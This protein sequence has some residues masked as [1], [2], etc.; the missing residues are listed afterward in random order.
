MSAGEESAAPSRSSWKTSE[1]V[2]FESARHGASQGGCAAERAA[3]V[4]LAFRP[5]DEGLVR[6]DVRGE[7]GGGAARHGDTAVHRQAGVA[8]GGGGPPGGAGAR[9]ADAAR[10]G[11]AGAGGTP[12]GPAGGH[13]DP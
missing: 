12:G 10:H 5:P 1:T 3:R 9:V 8:D 4:L 11:G 2:S 7:P 13:R 6:G